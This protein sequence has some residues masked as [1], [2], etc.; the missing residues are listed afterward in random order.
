MPVK[1]VIVRRLR[2]TD[3][4]EHA[5]CCMDG[6]PTPWPEA[7]CTCRRWL[8]EN[9]GRHVEGYHSV[10]ADGT[11]VG[12]LYYAPAERALIPYQV[13]PG[14]VVLYCEWIQQR[15]QGAGLGRRQFSIFLDA[16]RQSGAKG[17]LV[18]CRRPAAAGGSEPYPRRGFKSLL[19]R[20]DAELYYLPITQQ[21]IRV[22]VQPPRLR[23]WRGRPVEI[24]VLAG[25]RCPVDVA[26]LLLLRQVA[27]EFRDQVVL[28]ELVLSP[29][30]LS[31]FGSVAGILI[32]GRRT[33]FGG[34]TEESI[35]Q[36]ILEA[37]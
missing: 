32:N 37:F 28:R 11:T 27:Q 12:H 5:F 19:R 7:L 13:E 18:E 33:L 23:P 34:E 1:D 26:T 25:Y 14:V 17:I 15:Y 30:T 22:T 8:A 2:P 31:K 20:E 35:R 16:M 21:E 24:Q 10:L 4:P 9:L 3:D 29:Q 36:A 6:V